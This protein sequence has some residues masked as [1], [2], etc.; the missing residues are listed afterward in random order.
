MLAKGFKNN[1]L[2]FSFVAV[3]F[4]SSLSMSWV[5]LRA[6]WAKAS[7]VKCLITQ[8]WPP[9]LS[10]VVCI[11]RSWR[12]PSVNIG[13]RL[14]IEL[15]VLQTQYSNFKST[16]FFPLFCTPF[17]AWETEGWWICTME[18]QKWCH[19][20]VRLQCRDVIWHQC[21]TLPSAP[22]KTQQMVLG[23]QMC[24]VCLSAIAHLVY[25]DDRLSEAYFYSQQCSQ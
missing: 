2:A 14:L 5:N 19:V 21:F 24:L 13:L 12:M 25:L 8:K 20:M 18:K 17:W 22:Q 9:L 10:P 15:S 4:S 6:F 16:F 3:K 11:A 7:L 1:F 23:K